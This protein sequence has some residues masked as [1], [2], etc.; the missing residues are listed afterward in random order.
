MKIDKSQLKFGEVKRVR[1]RKYL[2][3]FRDKVCLAS[4]NGIDICGLPAIPAHINDGEM[5]GTA[6]KAGDDLVYPLCDRH[7]KEQ[8]SIKD[9]GYSKNNRYWFWVEKCFKPMVR[10]WYRDSKSRIRE[11]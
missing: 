7:H 1:D 4:D 5:A 11:N 8:G 10:R 9:N 2:D 3:S 6:N